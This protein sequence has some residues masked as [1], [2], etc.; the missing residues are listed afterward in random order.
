MPFLQIP[1]DL[2]AV[3]KSWIDFKNL[4]WGKSETTCMCMFNTYETNGGFR[5]IENSHCIRHTTYNDPT[6]NNIVFDWTELN[7]S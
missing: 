2:A 1:H 3:G 5:L 6:S 4:V 7:R